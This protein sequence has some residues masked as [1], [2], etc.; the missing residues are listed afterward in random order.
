MYSWQ[1]LYIG[2]NFF[3]LGSSDKAIEYLDEL[4]E[5]KREDSV[6]LNALLNK[7][8]ILLGNSDKD[9]SDTVVENY[10]T[11][12]GTIDSSSKV[13]KE[14]DMFSTI[15]Y[16][17]LGSAYLLKKEAALAKINFTKALEYAE[18]YQKPHIYIN[19]G[20]C[21]VDKTEKEKLYKELTNFIIENNL[22]LAPDNEIINFNDLHVL[23][24]LVS[25]YKYKDIF[26]PFFNYANNALYS[27]KTDYE[28]IY[29]AA[30]YALNSGSQE[31]SLEL[32]YEIENKNGVSAQIL[33]NTYQ[34]I[35]LLNRQD[36]AKSFSYLVKYA[37]L[38]DEHNNFNEPLQVI[39]YNSFIEI[40]DYLKKK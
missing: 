17:R 37:K 20:D 10:K 38:F 3:K 4:I 30:I 13:F 22:P 33:K 26:E 25:L 18:D 36:R 11:L 39:D 28:I 14:K 34:I 2:L 6:Y 24:I 15:A 31:I 5:E 19:I 1:K 40:I 21:I 12:L 8:E 23:A 29:E 32:L 16:Y 35:G 27:T 9:T 7:G